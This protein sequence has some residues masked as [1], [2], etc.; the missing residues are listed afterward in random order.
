MTGN[1]KGMELVRKINREWR[2]EL[3][4]DTSLS[5]LQ[6]EPLTDKYWNEE[7]K[8]VFCNL[9]P[10]GDPPEDKKEILEIFKYWLEINNLTI[11]NTATFVYCLYNILHGNEI[12]E[13]DKEIAK[14][15]NVKLMNVME[16]A[17]YM[18]L[19]QSVGYSDFSKKSKN[20]FWDFYAKDQI[21][22]RKNIVELI[23]A[24]SPDIFIV[25]GEGQDLIMELFSK[26]F[27]KN[28]VFLH[29]DTLFVALGHPSRW[30]KGYILPNV[31]LIINGLK[32]HNL[33]K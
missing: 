22:N 10:G 8:I 1:E 25:T 20:Y 16:K 2:L 29:N 33:I 19:L 5:I 30:W 24:L 26:K 7:Y 31:K 28:H 9:E 17:T 21:Q 3:E 11:K 18:N 12:S 14:K 13:N 27:D 23:N 4:K 32:T 15:D 6:Y